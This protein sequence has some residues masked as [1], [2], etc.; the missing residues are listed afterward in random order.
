MLPNDIIFTFSIK[1]FKN[2]TAFFYTLLN[3]GQSQYVGGPGSKWTAG[4]NVAEI[5]EVIWLAGK[6]SLII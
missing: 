5:A 6:L 3:D 2:G 1:I 4:W